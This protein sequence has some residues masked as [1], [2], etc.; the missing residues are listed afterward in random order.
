[1]ELGAVLG[2]P[3]LT[4]SAYWVESV[5]EGQ[6]EADKEFV[7]DGADGSLKSIIV[8]RLDP[9]VEFTMRCRSDATPTVTLVPGQN[10]TTTWFCESAPVTKTKG[11]WTITVRLVNIGVS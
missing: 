5:T 1:M 2:S 11:A 8:H 3:T 9:V 4:L 6:V 10:V 7:Y